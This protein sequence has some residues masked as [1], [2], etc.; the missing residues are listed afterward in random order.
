MVFVLKVFP[1]RRRNKYIFIRD[2]LCSSVSQ[3]VLVKIES[4]PYLCCSL[5]VTDLGEATCNRYLY[6]ANRWR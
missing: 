3:S 4:I 6:I 2:Y 5:H 1:R